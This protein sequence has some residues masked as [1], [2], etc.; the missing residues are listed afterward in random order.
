MLLALRLGALAALASGLAPPQVS[1][2]TPLRRGFE[3]VATFDT[4]TLAGATRAPLALQ[5]LDP[6]RFPTPSKAKRACRRAEV[7]LNGRTARCGDDV[8]AGDVLELRARTF[9]ESYLQARFRSA[10]APFELKVAY[11]DDY[12]AVVVKPSGRPTHSEGQG[13]MNLR[14][15]VP[16]ALRP[17]A[18]VDDGDRALSRPQPVHRLDKATSGLVLC[19]KTKNAAVECSRMFAERRVRNRA[20]IILTPSAVL[21]GRDGA[22]H[23][24]DVITATRRCCW[25]NR[26]HHEAS[27]NPRRRER[28]FHPAPARTVYAVERVVPSLKAESLTLVHFAPRTGRTHQLRRHAADVLRCPIVGDALYDGGGAAAMQFRRR[29]LFLCARYLELDHPCVP[30]ERLRVEIPLPA[31]FDDRRRGVLVAAARVRVKARR[32]VL[33]LERLA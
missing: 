29:G 1:P 31:K 14:S 27:S 4:S 13:R 8:R 11:E 16:F 5:V 21:R 6:R 7:A 32:P 3:V 28:S 9:V 25:A 24:L 15:A 12:L 18:K 30:G 20:E 22:E 10:K 17:P 19:A 2:A 26:L 23:K 33:D